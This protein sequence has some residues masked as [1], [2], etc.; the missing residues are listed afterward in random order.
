M[1][2]QI[3]WPDFS[4]YRNIELGLS[5]VFALLKRLGNPHLNLPAT[6]HLAGTN[7]KGSTLSFLRQ[8][9]VENGY[10]VHTYTSPHLVA[11][12][13]RIVLAN[14]EISDE[15]FTEIL[16]Q[17]QAAANQEPKINVT[18][19]EGLTVAAF[20]AFSKIP[21][22][23]LFLETGMGGKLDATNV[24]PE[25]LASIIT[26]IDLDHQDFLG[27]T[28]AK[29]AQE[30]CG[31]IKKNCPVFVA[32]QSNEA[33]E[34]ISET[35]KV[36]N[37]E[38]FALN[39]NF[40]LRSQ[41][42]SDLNQIFSGFGQ[43]FIMPK[44]SLEGAHQAEN[45]ALAIALSLWQ[46]KFT[47]NLEKTLAAVS[48]TFWPAR[49]QKIE[50]GNLRQILPPNLQL[51]LDGSHNPQGAS[52]IKKFLEQKKSCYK[53]A[54]FS[55][56]QDKDCEKFLEIISPEFDKFFVLEIPNESKS[57]QLSNILEVGK[58]IGLNMIS[59]QDFRDVFNQIALLPEV[60]NCSET[61]VVVCGSLYLAGEFLW[62]NNQ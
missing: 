59:G 5:R 21:A 62:Q 31:I 13:E 22:D 14:A 2:R 32:K 17:C 20:L 25:V 36:Q 11:F 48:K 47:L 57:R 28:I 3:H 10:R 43:E 33:L 46:K 4:G 58:N 16:N 55:M 42:S 56:L 54:V 12:N 30:K 44:I 50:Q 8:I 40:S 1:L 51:Y 26:P 38:L 23:I 53:V 27:D 19:F 7:G 61:I 37:S 6:I 41:K 34:V 49:L 9:F 60:K 18:F 35:C 29:I 52:T 15:F 45:A 39:K 24:L